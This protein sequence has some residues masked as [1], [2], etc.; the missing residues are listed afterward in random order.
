MTRSNLLR[1]LARGAIVALIAVSQMAIFV[2]T[3]HAGQECSRRY[4]AQ[5]IK[6]AVLAMKATQYC[7]G[8]EFPYTQQQVLDRLELLRCDDGA[9]ALIDELL[10]GFEKEYKEILTTDAKDTICMYAATLVIAPVAEPAE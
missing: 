6:D 2:P 8:H 7:V 9:I 3:A 4:I 10:E 1:P 5:N